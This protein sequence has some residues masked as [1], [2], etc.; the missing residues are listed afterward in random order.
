MSNDTKELVV[1]RLSKAD[2]AFELAKFAIE[3]GYWNSAASRLYYSCFYL[4]TSIFAAHSII[5]HSHNAVKTLFGLQFIKEG[6]VEARWGKL[7]NRLF[8]MRQMGDYGDFTAL[9]SEDILPLMKE[10]EE[11]K[12]VILKLLDI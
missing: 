6:L 7:F 4:V 3:K 9:T 8:N 2:E 10:V 5:T 1:Y 12:K 11:F